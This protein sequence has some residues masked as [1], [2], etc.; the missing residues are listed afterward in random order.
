[1]RLNKV[2]N[3]NKEPKTF[4]EFEQK[5]YDLECKLNSHVTRVIWKID[6]QQI[7]KWRGQP[8]KYNAEKVI[9]SKKNR[10]YSD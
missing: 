10:R 6:T 9:V 4:W 3:G 1:M 5:Y 7:R 2:K 8:L